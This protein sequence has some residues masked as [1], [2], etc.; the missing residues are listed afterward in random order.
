MVL[1]IIGFSLWAAYQIWNDFLGPKVRAYYWNKL[2]PEEQYYTYK[3]TCKRFY[4]DK[5]I[6]P[7]KQE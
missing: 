6:Y 4:P 5:I 7:Y 2:T 3:L 1:L